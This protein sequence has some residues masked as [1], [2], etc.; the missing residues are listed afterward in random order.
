[1]VHVTLDLPDDIDRKIRVYMALNNIKV[2]QQAI[3]EILH[4]VRFE[5][6]STDE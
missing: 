4:N 1:M 2:K 6:A 5:E 3:L